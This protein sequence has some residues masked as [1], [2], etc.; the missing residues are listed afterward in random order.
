MLIVFAVAGLR[1]G[2]AQQTSTPQ[3]EA[4]NG[5]PPPANPL[6]VAILHWYQVNKTASFKVG[7]QPYGLAFDGANIWSAN[8]E[9]RTVTK[10]RASDGENLG[11]FQAGGSPIGIVFD[12]ANMWVP[13]S[14]GSTVTKL[15]ASDGKIL[16]TF[17]VS[18]GPRLPAFDGENVWVPGSGGVT[19]LRASDGK[20]L[21][22]FGPGCIAAA[23][24]GTYIW[25]TTYGNAPPNV[26]RLREDGS[27]AGNFQA[28]GNPLSLA[29]DGANMWV[30]NH[31]SG[32]VTKF[33]AKDGKNLGEFFLSDAWGVAFDG[34]NIWVSGTPDVYELRPSD[35]K[36]IGRFRHHDSGAPTGIAFDG[37][38][39]WVSETFSNAI[40]KF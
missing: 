36:I 31:G 14:G 18:P 28:D 3:Q 29:F 34:E 9:D 19:K 20:N 25:L 38:S 8:Y 6:K 17:A 37:A 16:G 22:L 27:N 7:K 30:V 40:A 26:V 1:P 35:G 24:D 21:G 2:K 12:G 5:A 15:R 32:S 4:N 10:L 13:D 39:L 23:F 33:R 11:T